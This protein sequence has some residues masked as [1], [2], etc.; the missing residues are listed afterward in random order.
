[1]NKSLNYEE[2]FW[3]KGLEEPRAQEKRR[4]KEK[5]EKERTA[6]AKEKVVVIEG[7]DR[8]KDGKEM[9]N[10]IVGISKGR[11]RME[12]IPRMA[13]RLQRKTSS[14]CIAGRR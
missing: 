7:K 1:M 9:G 8:G 5:E 13:R 6:R 11:Q 4:E 3:R 12:R 2:G 14:S 10:T